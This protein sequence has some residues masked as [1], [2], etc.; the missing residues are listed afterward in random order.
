MCAISFPCADSEQREHRTNSFKCMK[1][2]RNFLIKLSL[3]MNHGVLLTIRKANA[4]V[5]LGSALGCPRQRN[6]ASKSC[7]KTMLVAFFDSLGLIHK[8]FVPSGQ[9][10]NA[11]FYIIKMFWIILSKELTTFV[12]ICVRLEIGFFSMTTHQPTM[13]HR[14]TSFWPKKMLQSFITLPI[15]QIWLRLIIPSQQNATVF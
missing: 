10:V 4:S 2:V 14:F 8:E 5:Q 12:R 11:N 15:P 6:F 3:A 9:T 13:R 7:V 1:M